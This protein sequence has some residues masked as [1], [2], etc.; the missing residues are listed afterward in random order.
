MQAPLSKLQ[1]K[2]TPLWVNC[3]DGTFLCYVLLPGKKLALP[4]ISYYLSQGSYLIHIYK[5]KQELN[6]PVLENMLRKGL[7]TKQYAWT[8]EWY[9][10]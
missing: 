3:K 2:C 4:G 6:S 5:V 9:S 10:T 7:E 1:K 8:N